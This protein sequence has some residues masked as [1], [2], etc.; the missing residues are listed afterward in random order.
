MNGPGVLIAHGIGGR[1]DLP[2]DL[3]IAVQ[4]AAVAVFVSFVAVALLWKEP[5]LTGGAAGRPIPHGVQRVI[6]APAFRVVVQLV[7]LAL[8][9]FVVVAGLIG[10]EQ[11]NN[12][13]APWAFYITFWIGI[14]LIASLL[15]GPVWRIV[16]PLRLV[17]GLLARVS[18]SRPE[19]GL[20]PLPAALGY[21][22]AVISLLAFLWLE[23]VYSNRE[24]PYVV[25]VFIAV[26]SAAHLGA[27]AVYGSDWFAK[28]DGFE[29]YSTAVGKLSV[30]G[31]RDDGRLV[32]RNPLDGLASHAS[33]PGFVG[34]I[35]V[36]IGSTAFDG[37]TRTLLWQDNVRSDDTLR[38]SLGLFGCVL[39]VGVLYTL[40]TRAAGRYARDVPGRAFP[41]ALAAS[42]I[43]IAVGYGIA[44]Y[45]SLLIGDGQRV[46]QLASD[47]LG[48]GTNY[49]GTALRRNNYT[50]LTQDTVAYIQVG[51][52]V[53]GHIVGVF[54]A[55]DRSAALL[56]PESRQ[57]GQFPMIVLMVALT[58]L[59]VYLLFGTG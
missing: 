40:A 45:L 33:G 54:S 21:W 23:L 22:P 57:R 29:V 38:G 56:P 53:I 31:R 28:G 19:E 3:A 27:A 41:A 9:A 5:R 12:N 36:L 52:I 11:V 6:D 34:V 59:G 4:G 24:S 58:C 2:V 51:A 14:L 43:P 35:A 37:V 32:V 20:R 44:H 46:I 1:S 8:S 47:P 15:L 7:A 42:L 26:Y 10:S 50:L 49:F 13:I 30:F 39:I 18:G 16:N 55:H 17:H 25:S 48:N